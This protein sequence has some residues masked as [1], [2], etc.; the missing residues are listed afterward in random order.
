M[1]VRWR[2]ASP[3]TPAALVSL[4]LAMTPELYTS[5]FFPFFHLPSPSLCFLSMCPFDEAALTYSHLFMAIVKPMTDISVITAI[6]SLGHVSHH[7][8]HT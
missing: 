2:Y 3:L 6:P 1:S 8:A 5:S 7:P 4:A